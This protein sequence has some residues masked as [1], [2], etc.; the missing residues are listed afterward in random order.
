MK[1]CN[2]ENGT[3]GYR[4]EATEQVRQQRVEVVLENLL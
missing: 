1:N 4:F 2:S 3:V